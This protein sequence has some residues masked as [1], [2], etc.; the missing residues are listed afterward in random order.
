MILH[1][2][3]SDAA[4]LAA[5]D[6]WVALLETEQYQSAFEATDH[7]PA[8]RW[9]ANLVRDV[10]ARYGDA[11]PGQKVTLSGRPS[12]ITQRK[13]VQRFPKNKLGFIGHICYD[14]NINGLASDL[15]ATFGLRVV[16]EGL[17]LVLEDIHV[18]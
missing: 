9:D 11:V 2:N 3:A 6:L 1:E 17:A 8:T 18:M 5:V 10:I 4:I 13:N 15:T 12:D 14:L 7:D 16:P